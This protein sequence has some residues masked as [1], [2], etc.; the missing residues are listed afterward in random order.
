MTPSPPPPG[1][2]PRRKRADAVRNREAVV[3]AAGEVFT[4]RGPEAS[5][6]DIAARA[7][8]GKATVYRSFPTKEHLV[9]A[10]AA[11]RLRWLATLSERALADEHADAWVAIRDVLRAAARTRDRGVLVH[12]LRSTCD[13]AELREA[14]DRAHAAGSAL[15]DRGRAQS[16]I[17]DDVTHDDLLVL[18]RGVTLALVDTGERDTAVWERYSDL[19]A[20]ALR[21]R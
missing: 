16:T 17:R 21:A 5:V 2:P 12:G 9:A 13:D 11:D 19:V 6:D 14:I 18:F 8:V 3:R 10:V 1:A 15:V 7:G 20:D 4:E